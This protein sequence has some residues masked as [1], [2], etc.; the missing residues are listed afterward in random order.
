[1]SPSDPALLL[2]LHGSRDEK[3]AREAES[4]AE[5]LRCDRP[6][7]E[8]RHGFI[9]FNSPSLAEAV[10]SIRANGFTS[11]V[12]LPLVLLGAG[13]YKDDGPS[14][15]AALRSLCPDKH[16]MY[17]EPLGIALEV[18]NATFE[19]VL[20]AGQSPPEGVLLVGRGSTDPDANSDLYKVARLLADLP[21][22]PR[23]VEA[24]FVS[25]TWP[26]VEEGLERLLKLGA[27]SVCVMPYFLFDGVLVQRIYS[28]AK[29]WAAARG[30]VAL[31]LARPLGDHPMIKSLVWRRYGEAREGHVRMS[32]DLCAYRVRIPGY[33]HKHGKPIPPLGHHH[34]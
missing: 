5:S 14:A 29:E 16:V 15:V 32:C 3:G 34:L 31:N 12:C 27:S 17:A 8:V 10:E 7:T 28:T 19:R 25:L 9:E 22:A 18:I 4:F 6:G 26:S 20:E 24:S 1:M 11:L 30:S 33:E 23:L 21:G 2:I 13:H